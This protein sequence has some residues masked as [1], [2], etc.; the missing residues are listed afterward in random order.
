MSYEI[1]YIDKVVKDD[2]SKISGSYRDRIKLAIETR[3]LTKPDLYGKPLR[4]SLKGYLKLRVG[5]YRI[6]FRIENQKVKIFAIA[7]RRVVY[8]IMSGRI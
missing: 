3:L 1:L 4:R 2:I 7:H 8:E 5:D 6:V